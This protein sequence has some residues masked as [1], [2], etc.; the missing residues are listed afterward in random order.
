MMRQSSVP[1]QRPVACAPRRGPHSHGCGRPPRGTRL[2]PSHAADAYLAADVGGT[3]AR[4]A[5]VA[6]GAHHGPPQLLHYAK[7]A[8]AQYPGLEPLLADFVAAA[9]VAVR[10]AVIASAGCATEDGTVVAANLPW[11]VSPRRLQA[12]LALERLWLVNDFEALAHAAARL[13]PEQALHLGGP[14]TPGPGPV[15]VLGPGTG[16]GAALWIPGR[17]A[18]CVLPSEAGQAALAT[19]TAL[20]AALLEHM[21]QGR[22]HVPA[23]HALS[24]PGLLHLYRALCAVRGVLPALDTPA[25]VTAAAAAG[26]DPLAR[27]TLEVF[28]GLLGGMAGDLALVTGAASVCLAGGILPHIR[29]FLGPGGFHAR[30]LDKGPMRLRLQQVCIRLVEHGQL[31]VAGAAYWYRDNAPA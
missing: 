24:G 21:R 9:D 14:P 3:Y 4:V 22:S 28:C 20:E 23:E 10:H 7:Y 30:F 8:C 19:G 12:A 15:L 11:T 31:G 1:W 5:L 17:D 18:P 2:H 13:S 6:G 16:L 25:A 27:E 29:P 26:D